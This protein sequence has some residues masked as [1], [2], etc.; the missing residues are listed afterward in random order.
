MKTII[1]ALCLL[2]STV[3]MAFP[4]SSEMKENFATCSTQDSNWHSR[5][6][7]YIVSFD[8]A[9]ASN[10]CRAQ[11]QNSW[12]LV[13]RVAACRDNG[14]WLYAGYYCENQGR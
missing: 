11:S 2:G 13:A 9:D 4:S 7:Q 8:L 5:F 1:L 14:T 12:H 6:G 3:A 10:I